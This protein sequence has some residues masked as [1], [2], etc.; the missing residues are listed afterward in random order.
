M[1][2]HSL[3]TR[4]K[5]L[6]PPEWFPRPP[7]NAGEIAGLETRYGIRLPGAIVNSCCTR[8]EEIWV[9]RR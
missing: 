6:Q 2:E 1:M 5:G 4:L 9:G 8:T 7:G 3:V